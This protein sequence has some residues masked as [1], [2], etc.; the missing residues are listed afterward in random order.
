MKRRVGLVEF[1]VHDQFPLVSGYLHAY[2]TADPAIA[3]EFEFVYYQELIERVEYTETLSQLRALKASILCL[4]CYVWNM[5]LIKRLVRDLLKDPSI[6]KIILG[7]H[8][9]SHHITQY[10]D[11]SEAKIIVINGQGEIPFRAILQRLIDSGDVAGLQG[12]SAYIGGELWNGGEAQMIDDLDSIPS[13]FLGGQFDRMAHPITTFETNRG[14]PY[15][16]TFCTWG[17]DTLKVAKFSLDRVK[18]ELDWI[19]KKSVI[20]IML[21]DANWGMLPRDV[22]I[23]E[24]M[25]RL[26]KERGFPWI[27]YMASAKNT[28][29]RSLACIEKLH[30][31][32]VLASQALGIQS[33]NPGTLELVDRKN[34]KNAAYIEL[35]QQL[36]ARKIDSFCELIWPL[37]G[38]TLETLKAGFEQLLELGAGT[39]T[40]HPTVLINNARLT[41]QA[42]EHEIDSSDSDD[43]KSELK[44]VQETKYASST[45]VDEGRWFFYGYFL[46]A[47]CDPHRALLRYLKKM[48][49]KRYADIISSFTE[50]IREDESRSSYADCVRGIFRDNRHAS[51]LALGGITTHLLHEGRLSAQKD[52]AGFLV[53]MLG[54]GHITRG[55]AFASVWSFALPRPFLDGKD[56]PAELLSVLDNLGRPFGQS[57]SKLVN[58]FNRGNT[59]VLGIRGATDAFGEALTFFT[60]GVQSGKLQGVE[61]AHPVKG[62][63]GYNRMDPARNAVYANGMIGRVSALTAS[64]RVH[65]ATVASHD[66][67]ASPPSS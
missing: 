47:N 55:L 44:I 43:W 65:S 4:S 22:D 13:P 30:E 54:P 35:F 50:Y 48:T 18:E 41:A 6:E 46:L 62:K 24:Y 38:E 3:K 29:S 49:G 21:A 37:P 14:C 61:I 31:G 8:Q 64:I 7:G 40:M 53:R 57:C 56:N 59:V 11:S 66:S 67:I 63:I 23:S 32:G 10:F 52:V 58:V 5:G 17:G 51:A 34:I 26:K 16:C 33:M 19:A 27:V 25:A 20:F 45:D 39:I 1:S 28:P 42:A 12:V 36:K 2:A 15:K 9:V 60:E